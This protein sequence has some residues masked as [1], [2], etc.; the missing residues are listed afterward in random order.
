DDCETILWWSSCRN[1]SNE[2]EL[3]D[4]EETAALSRAGAQISTATERERLRQ[5]AA[6][7]GLR[8]APHLIC[9]CPDRIRG[10][11]TTLHPALSRLA[12][13]IT[14]ARPE[15]FTARSEEHT[16]ELQSRFDL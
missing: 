11:E 7:R 12:E 1:D 10:E 6:L 16:S 15:R 13:D 8:H 2:T 9:F 14:A 4:P 5:A 3:W